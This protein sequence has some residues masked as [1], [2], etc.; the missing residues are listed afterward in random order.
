[1]MLL[2]QRCG[3]LAFI[4]IWSAGQ[5]CVNGVDPSIATRPSVY[6][7]PQRYAPVSVDSPSSDRLGNL[8]GP[9]SL[10]ADGLASFWLATAWKGF[11]GRTDLAKLR[12]AG[13]RALQLTECLVDIPDLRSFLDR[14]WTE[15]L[16]VVPQ[17]PARLFSRDSG[18]C[19]AEDA[20]CYDRVRDL[21]RE[22]LQT[23]LT[24]DGR[25][26]PAVD[27]ILLALDLDTNSDEESAIIAVL[28]AWDGLLDAESEIGIQS[29]QV[30]IAARFVRAHQSASDEATCY[31]FRA[32]DACTRPNFL[33]RFWYG[34]NSTPGW[35]AP[36]QGMGLLRRGPEN[37]TYLAHSV[38]A[39][40][41]RTRWVHTF[42]DD[43]PSDDVLE[44]LRL[45]YE[46]IS[47]A[48]PPRRDSAALLELNI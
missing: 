45:F 9:G 28:S 29:D 20:D 39:E 18:G 46:F 43:A 48:E 31:H 38:L 37:N 40:S 15:G 34:A 22:L 36:R 44:T 3:T 47:P 21:S 27:F 13:V 24:R 26:H 16:T 11:V 35:A 23:D 4:V 41:M 1:M 2:H 7:P 25:Y 5:V 10:A 32:P 14:A 42:T 33:R 12:V 19:L 8:C 17:I 6:R 30:G